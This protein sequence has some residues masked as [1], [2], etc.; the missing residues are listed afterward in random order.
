MLRI[1]TAAVAD[2]GLE[3]SSPEEPTKSRL[4]GWFLTGRQQAPRHKPAPFFPEVHDE[5]SKSWRAF[6]A[7]G[8]AASALHTMAVLQV[9]QAKLLQALDESGPDPEMFKELC[10][11][12][13]L[14]LRATKTTARSRDFE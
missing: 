3:W 10:S 1:L 12:T 8:Q 4:D 14:A 2:L 9:Y 6:S 11:V 13:D 5:L 7:S